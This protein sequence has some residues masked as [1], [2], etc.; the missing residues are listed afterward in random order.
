MQE[1]GEYNA[2][3]AIVDDDPSVRRGLKRLIR[4][5]GWKAETFASA[6]EFLARPR[7]E[8]PGCL[9][10]DLQLPGLGGLELQKQIGQG[11]AYVT[12][13]RFAAVSGVYDGRV[14]FITV[15]KAVV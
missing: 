8:A 10:L 14:R 9:V 6:Q 2:L 4:S 1:S 15:D 11:L 12:D 3:V 7:T 13:G 5:V